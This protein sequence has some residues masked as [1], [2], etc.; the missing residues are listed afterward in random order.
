MDIQS[1]SLSLFVIL[2]LVFKSFQD[3]RVVND[4]YSVTN[5]FCNSIQDLEK[6][7]NPYALNVT[8][9]SGKVP[10]S[11]LSLKPSVSVTLSENEGFTEEVLGYIKDLSDLW[12][13]RLE[14]TTVTLKTFGN[15]PLKSIRIDHG[16]IINIEAGSFSR[17][18]DLTEV[19]IV[20]NDLRSVSKGVFNY[21][22]I[23]T[24]ALSNNKIRLL[25]DG[26]F[27]NMKNLKHLY[28]D[29]NLITNFQSNLLMNYKNQLETLHIQSN[30]IRL[31]DRNTFKGFI[32]LRVLNLSNNRIDMILNYSFEEL[33]NLES[34]ALANN[35]LR[36]LN[37]E[38]F[39]L[40]PFPYLSKFNIGNNRFSHLTT[41]TLEKVKN[42]KYISIAGNPWQCPCL[43]LI[44][45]WTGEY[46]ITHVCDGDYFKGLR[47]ICVVERNNH[48]KCDYN[49]DNH[50]I[51][52]Y[53]E[54]NNQF[55]ST[56]DCFI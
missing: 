41:E 55:M 53:D 27:A 4:E 40:N 9:S 45:M 18:L 17:M 16:R 35:F 19:Y 32:N 21:L 39:P 47:P 51:Y 14:L 23:E 31:I 46:N 11:W 2:L 52:K 24:L 36:D 50:E 37:A 42:V 13:R 54:E 5:Y 8:I 49:D 33:L 48:N 25:E 3:C 34:L 22:N 44:L 10:L 43:N 29:G 7:G 28:L 1:V 12:D 15:L 38:I 30:S 20:D 6:Q 26:A 56:E